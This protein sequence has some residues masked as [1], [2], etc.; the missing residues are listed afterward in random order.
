MIGRTNQ[1]QYAGFITRLVALVID[2]LVI[3]AVTASVSLA[4]RLIFQ[5]FGLGQY[6]PQEFAGYLILV[7]AALVAVF[8]LIFAFFYAIFFWRISGQTLGK[9]LMGIRVVSTDGQ[10][11]TF[12]RGVVRFLGYW[13]STLVFF[14]GFLWALADDRR[15]TW[16]DKFAK[17]YVIYAWEAEGQG[18]LV[19][20]LVQ[21][22]Q[23]R[24]SPPDDAK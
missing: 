5:F 19:S 10:F 16:H 7:V 6:L 13:V 15:Q 2:I 14:I 3:N 21:R 1:G 24:L 8:T 12:R 4:A 17:T 20:G 18:K 23:R 22:R 9:A 11:I